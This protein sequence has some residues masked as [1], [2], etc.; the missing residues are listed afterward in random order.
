MSHSPEGVP[1]EAGRGGCWRIDDLARRA[2][3][4]V[5]TIRYYQREGLL[6]PAERAGRANLYGPSPLEALARIKELQ[7]RRFSLAAIRALLT[8]DRG[9]FVEGL[10]GGAEGR[11]YTLDELIDRSGID[12]ELAIEVHAAG[13][14]REP[15]EYGRD[16]YDA[17]DLELVQT[18]AE[19]HRLGVPR[20][21]VVEMARTY[22]EGIEAT[23]RRVVELFTTGGGIDWT[24]DEFAAFQRA[25]V[26][27][28]AAILPLARQLVDYT[29]H[30]TI[31]RL[32]LGAI[33]RGDL[34]PQDA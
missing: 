25:A 8:S 29:H 5:D 1:A 20:S 32:T 22:A 6:P 31:Q 2:D 13:V 28:A 16:A 4:T 7:G 24:D 30:R 9:D 34:P 15:Q 21:A 12:R 23:Q 19:L 17:E 18:L 14:L 11:T 3:V 10:F 26:A 33:E 27:H